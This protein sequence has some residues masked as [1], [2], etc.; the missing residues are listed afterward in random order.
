A[1]AVSHELISVLSVILTT[2]AKTVAAPRAITAN[3]ND[4]RAESGRLRSVTFRNRVPVNHVPPGF[5]IIGPA[6]LVIEIVS[7]FPNVAAEDR[8]VPIHQR[9]VLIRRRNHFQLAAFVFDN[10]Y[11]PAA[12]TSN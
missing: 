3:K 12:D 2:A 5:D 9:A 7:V 4:S 6:V 8:R 11:P 10:A 1:I